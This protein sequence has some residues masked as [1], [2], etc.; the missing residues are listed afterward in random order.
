[1]SLHTASFSPLAVFNHLRCRS[2]VF[3]HADYPCAEVLLPRFNGWTADPSMR[4]AT[5]PYQCLETTRIIRRIQTHTQ[6]GSSMQAYNRFASL[7]S[8]WW[9][10]P[11]QALDEF[12]QCRG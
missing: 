8:L 6:S 2:T 11:L 12:L 4:K 9:T 5:L 7:A 1:M 3:L 10:Q